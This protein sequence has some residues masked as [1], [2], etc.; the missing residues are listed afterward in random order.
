MNSQ[1]QHEMKEGLVERFLEA[2]DAVCEGTDL[3]VQLICNAD[4]R[5][6]VGQY[7][8]QAQRAL[9]KLPDAMRDICRDFVKEVS[10]GGHGCFLC[11]N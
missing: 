10:Q 2:R 8:L 3:R 7:P 1:F 6:L 9:G 4:L 5:N 11:L